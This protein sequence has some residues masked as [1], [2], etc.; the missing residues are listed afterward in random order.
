MSRS[1]VFAVRA[2]L[3]CGIVALAACQGTDPGCDPGTVPGL[4]ISVVDDTGSTGTIANI[5][6]V[7]RDGTWGDSVQAGAQNPT[8]FLTAYDRPGTYN[9]I[10]T[11]DRVKTFIVNGIVVQLNGCHVRTTNITATMVPQ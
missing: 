11:G 2:S 1:T 8:S 10:V 9:V 4:D 3:V 7:A 6:I 5:K